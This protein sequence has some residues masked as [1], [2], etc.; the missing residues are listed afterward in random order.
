M[1]YVDV[2]TYSYPYEKIICV[3]KRS[4]LIIILVLS[5]GIGT[6]ININLLVAKWHM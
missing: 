1:F 5:V 6:L 3:N 4:A 2:I